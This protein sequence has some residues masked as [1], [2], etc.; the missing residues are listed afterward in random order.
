MII[1]DTDHFSILPFAEHPRT[2]ALRDRLQGEGENSVAATIITVEEQARGWLARIQQKSE[3]MQQVPWY[4]RF[5]QWTYLIREWQFVSF[6][7][8]AAR[9]FVELRKQRLRIGTQD[10]KIAAI[11]LV[12]NAL[13]LSANLRDF[14]RIP[15]L[16]VENWLLPPRRTRTD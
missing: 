6:D 9:E 2:V 13:L 3:P 4:D 11:A 15:N 16:R 8:S 1:L 14:K 5:Q 10:L 7:E 12:N